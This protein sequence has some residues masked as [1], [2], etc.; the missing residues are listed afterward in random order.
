MIINTV[1]KGSGGGAGGTAV[2]I[3]SPA[4]ATSGTLTAEQLATLQS[5]NNNYIIFNNEIYRLADKQ[6][7]T[8]I[9]SYTHNGWNGTAMQD[10]SINIT[11]STLAWS[12]VVGSSVNAFNVSSFIITFSDITDTTSTVNDTT[13]YALTDDCKTRLLSWFNAIDFMKIISATSVRCITS[14]AGYGT[15]LPVRMINQGSIQT[16]ETV[17]DSASHLINVNAGTI[18]GELALLIKAQ[19]NAVFSLKVIS[20]V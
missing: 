18:Q 13:F 6:H 2:E 15:N 3:T 4:S 5:N 17:N 11:I 20:E 16:I 19:A 1:I 8:G 12:L 14:T 9:L 7:T 10:K